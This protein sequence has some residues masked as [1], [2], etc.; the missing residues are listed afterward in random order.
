M[1]CAR[2]QRTWPGPSAGRWPGPRPAGGLCRAG[3]SSA[4]RVSQARRASHI[5]VMTLAPAVPL[6]DRPCP[7]VRAERPAHSPFH[8]RSYTCSTH[9]VGVGRPAWWCYPEQCADGHEWGP[10][11]VILSWMPCDCGPA[12]AMQEQSPGH[13]VVYCR[14]QGCESAW[15]SPRHEPAGSARPGC[16]NPRPAWHEQEVKGREAATG[17][18]NGRPRVVRPALGSSE[19]ANNA[20][21]PGRPSEN[22]AQAEAEAAS[23][24]DCVGGR[25]YLVG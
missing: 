6:H 15:Y 20:D 3:G 12:Q 9:L 18:R 5:P 2:R 21:T 16:G 8:T 24:P 19:Q 1:A 11:R 13:L 17:E 10:G 4:A 7:P 23:K 25:L 22:I 14:A